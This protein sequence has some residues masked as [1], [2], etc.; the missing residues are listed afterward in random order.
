[1]MPIVVAGLVGAA[2]AGVVLVAKKSGGPLK[3][4]HPLTADKV[5]L[6]L[7]EMELR[8]TPFK[9]FAG[10]RTAAQQAA[11]YAKGRTTSGP[12]VTYK[13]GR[14]GDESEHQAKADGY[15]RAVDL[16][17]DGDRWTIAERPINPWDVGVGGGRVVRPQVLAAWKALGQS[18]FDVGLRWGGGKSFGKLDSVTGMAFDPGHLEETEDF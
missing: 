12:I 11:L 15:G 6:V 3:G 7:E 5:R 10:V 14:P 18:A 13:S 9:V 17:A 1:M 8:G 4:I 2:L 16:V